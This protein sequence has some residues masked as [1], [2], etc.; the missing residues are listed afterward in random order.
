MSVGKALRKI[1]K[2]E[3]FK[4]YMKG[5]GANCLRIVPYS[6]VQFGS[7]N[8]YKRFFESTPGQPLD[9]IQRLGCGAAAGVTSVTA[10]YPLDIVRTRLSIQ[11]ASFA[12]RG[13]DPTERLPGMAATLMHMYRTEGGVS[14]LYRG[15]VPTVAGVAP[16]VSARIGA[17]IPMVV[18]DFLKGWPQLHGLRV[19]PAVFYTSRREESFGVWKARRRCHIWSHRTNVHIPI[20]GETP[21]APSFVCFLWICVPNTLLFTDLRL[22]H[23][24]V[25]RRRFQINTM[26]GLGY[27]YTSIWGAITSI[28]KQEGA[29]GLY[30]GM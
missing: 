13:V 21:F 5:N 19:G 23:S 2:E 29:R 22:Y 18:A 30:K 1:W 15:I 25:L 9:A 14:A 7:Y 11:T 28:V 20:V 24:D 3:G 6:A 8:L 10:T 4:G 16:Y 27:Q 12:R 26:S 17:A